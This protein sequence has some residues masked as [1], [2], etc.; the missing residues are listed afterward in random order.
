M[1]HTIKSQ[2][3]T[4]LPGSNVNELIREEITGRTRVLRIL[5]P[6]FPCVCKVVLTVSI[7]VRIILNAAAA[8]DENI[9]LTNDHICLR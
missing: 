8:R 7:G 1:R 5:M 6:D 2:Y 3:R 9:V 4:F